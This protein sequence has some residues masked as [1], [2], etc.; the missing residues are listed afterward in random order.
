MK[1]IFELTGETAATDIQG[2]SV[3]STGLKPTQ[4]LQDVM[5]GAKKQMYFGSSVREFTL[6]SG[7]Y[8]MVIPKRIRYFAQSDATWNTAG[9][10]NG[11][12]STGT[13]PYANTQANMTF[14]AYDKV[15]SIT[16]KPLPEIVGISFRKWDLQTNLLNLMEM[17]KEDLM[18]LVADR[19]ESKIVTALGDATPNASTLS[20]CTVLYGG[21]ATSENTLAAGDVLTTDLIAKGK[22]RLQNNRFWYRAS[23]KQYGAETYV[24]A[25][26]F[27][28]PWR[29]TPDDPFVLYVGPSQMEALEKDSQFVNAS[30]YGGREVVLNGEE[31]KLKYIGVKIV[32]TDSLEQVASGGAT[33]DGESSTAGT[34][35]TRCILMKPKT[36]VAIVYGEKPYVDSWELKDQDSIRVAVKMVLAVGI[37][38]GDA[39]VLMDVANA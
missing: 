18:H 17:A 11:G 24:T 22:S 36:A 9:S 5:D 2:S 25:T 19:V 13:G 34:D 20:G 1:E 30:E 35:M 4:Y 26:Y 21:D 38:Q 8:Q 7:H 6:T 37:V 27:K 14:T 33:I 15:D 39:I 12:S 28:N 10:D 16:V 32:M 3:T 31:G 29:S 23:D